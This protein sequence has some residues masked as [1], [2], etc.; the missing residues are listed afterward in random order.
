MKLQSDI[1]D[2]NMKRG[3]NMTPIMTVRP[4]EILRGKLKRIA[5]QR[6]LPLNSLVIQILWE[7]VNQINMEEE[8]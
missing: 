8:K 3:M 2:S 5:K 1:T 4:P 6:G 7:W